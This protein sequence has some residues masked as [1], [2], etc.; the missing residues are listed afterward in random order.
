VDCDDG[1]PAVNPG[2]QEIC[3]D[4]LDNNCDGLTDAADLSCLCGNGACGAGA[5]TATIL[6]LWSLF[7]AKVTRRRRRRSSIRGA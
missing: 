4:G 5:A 3:D 7:A 2:A 1:N 6:G